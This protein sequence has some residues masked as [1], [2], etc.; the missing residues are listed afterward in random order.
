MRIGIL[1][2]GQL[3]RMIALAG[4]PLGY[5][6]RFLDRAREPAAADLGE[7]IT[8]DFSDFNGLAR[9]AEGLDL[10][11]YEFENVPIAAAEFLA[12]RLPVFPPPAALGVAQDRWAEKQFFQQLGVPIARVAAADT[13]E[14][15]RQAVG[16]L[17]TPVVLKTRR[18][19]YDGKGQ[20]VLRDARNLDAA[21]KELHGV[22]LVV[23]AFVPF[24]RE[25]SI[26]GVRGRKGETAFYPLTENEHED[27]ILRVSIAPAPNI[28]AELQK[29][30]ETYL[31]RVMDAHGYVGVIALE[32][33][34]QGDTLLA[35]ELAPRVHNSGHWTIEGSVASQFENHVR[36][37][38]G[39]PLGSTETIGHCAMVNL[40]GRM[41]DP[42]ALLAIEGAHLHLYGKESRARRKLGHVTIGSLTE[43]PTRER[44]DRLQQIVRG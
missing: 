6:F 21:W 1:G 3:G 17:G 13:L 10:V 34:Q 22:P 36:A 37:I 18:L 16:E 30:A 31:T 20:V 38:A 8:A 25:L 43:A 40:I 24:D 2:A 5:R 12:A 29:L 9:F 19:G 26:I 28:T 42:A 23:E 32:L 35:N 7:V 14:E 15:L 41:P 11:T 44:L 4:Y 27:G 39:L 33:F